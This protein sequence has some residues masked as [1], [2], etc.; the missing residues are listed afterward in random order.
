ML[1]TRN[2][3]E[4][5]REPL[6]YS[7]IGSCLIMCRITGR[8]RNRPVR[9]GGVNLE[10]PVLISWESNAHPMKL[11]SGHCQ[12]GSFAGAVSSKRVTEESKAYLIVVGNHE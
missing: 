10:I 8:L 7:G 5:P 1:F 11:G 9:G 2:K 12:T 3:T 4:R 6:L